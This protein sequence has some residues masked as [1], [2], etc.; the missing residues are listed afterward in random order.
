MAIVKEANKHKKNWS[1]MGEGRGSLEPLLICHHP[2]EVTSAVSLVPCLLVT[3]QSTYI[4][5]CVLKYS[6]FQTVLKSWN[7]FNGS[8][9][10]F[11]NCNGMAWDGMRRNRI[12]NFQSVLHVVK[13]HSVN[14]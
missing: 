14:M 4:P 9:P 1:I 7:E 8:L 2:P 3:Y 10:A 11:E 12:E 6:M 13:F 5:K